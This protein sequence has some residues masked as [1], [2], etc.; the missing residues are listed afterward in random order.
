MIQLIFQPSIGAGQ[1]SR[2]CC[3]QQLAGPEGQFERAVG[4]EIVAAVARSGSCSPA[5]R[6]TGF[7][8]GPLRAQ[9]L[10]PCV[11]RLKSLMPGNG[12]I[13]DCT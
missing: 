3:R 11:G 9:Q 6:S 8:Y 5:V 12:R 4:A 2:N 10:A 1:N 13:V 7:V